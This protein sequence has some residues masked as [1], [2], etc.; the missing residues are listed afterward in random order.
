MK[1]LNIF[2][3]S[4]CYD[5]SQIRVDLN[6]HI[7]DSGYNPIL[8]EFKNFPIN[9]AKRTIENCI[10]AVKDDADIFVLIVGNRYGSQIETGRSITNTEF[11]AA[12]SKG[13]PIYIFIDKKILNILAVWRNNQSGNFSDIVDTTKIFEFISELRDDSKLWT[14]EFDTAQDIIL[15]LKTQLSY[16]F[17]E[18]LRIRAKFNE[19]E[20]L[21]KLNLSNEALALLVEKSKI[22]ELEFFFQTM[23]DEIKKKETLKKDYDYAITLSSKFAIYQNSELIY[24]AQQ[25]IAVLS[26]LI[27]S[28]NKLI[29]KAFPVFYAEPGIPSDLKGL[30]Y[31]SETYARVYENIIHW[32]IDTASTCVNDECINL[33]DKLA[34]L[35]DK[36]ISQIWEFPFDQMD[37]IN[38]IRKKIEDGESS[39]ELNSMLT[40]D[41]DETDMANYMEEF[42][43]FGKTVL[44]QTRNSEY[45]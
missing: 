20:D 18:S 13:I 30:Y 17:K 9:P 33:R 4:T 32:T 31:I 6:E 36:A 24:W 25:R 37:A 15:I 22:F 11:L 19:I 43:N 21:F 27:D 35:S 38:R 41:I 8:S 39:L 7:E 12:R 23:I 34:K 28:L 44:A 42:E 45:N 16:L 2:V 10:D 40:I 1:K 26:S 3:S 29:K 5:L 14:F